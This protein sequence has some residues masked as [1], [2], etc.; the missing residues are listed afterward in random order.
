MNYL[1]E[2]EKERLANVVCDCLNMDCPQPDLADWIAMVDAW[3][4]PKHKVQIALVANMSL[5]MMP[6]S[7]LWKR[8]NMA[9]SPITPKWRSNGW[10]PS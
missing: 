6:I 7:A 3:K 8:S 4:N 5:C 2:M 9:L 1:W 10:I